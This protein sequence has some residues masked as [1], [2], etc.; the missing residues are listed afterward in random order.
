MQ[1]VVDCSDWMLVQLCDDW[2]GVS[3]EAA[4]FGAGDEAGEEV[5]VGAEGRVDVRDGEGVW[6][7]V[8][9]ERLCSRIQW[10][11]DSDGLVGLIMMDCAQLKR[12]IWWMV[13]RLTQQG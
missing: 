10:V 9:S 13:G 4:Y 11:V 8:S 12:K 7:W 1:C 5:V 6:G 2:E 3:V